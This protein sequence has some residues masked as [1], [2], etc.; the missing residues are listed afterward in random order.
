[1]GIQTM[2]S[3]IDAD[4]VEALLIVDGYLDELRNIDRER[5]RRRNGG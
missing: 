5:D 1:M 3:E 4:T 2:I